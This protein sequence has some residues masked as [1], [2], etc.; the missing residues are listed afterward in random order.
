MHIEP[1][2]RRT[3]TSTDV[4]GEA[5]RVQVFFISLSSAVPVWLSWFPVSGHDL[6][7]TDGLR[8][9]SAIASRT[10]PVLALRA[11]EVRCSSASNWPSP[12]PCIAFAVHRENVCLPQIHCRRWPLV[13]CYHPCAAHG[14]SSE[15]YTRIVTTPGASI[16]P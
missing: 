6:L 16:S 1:D 12:C 10:D 14:Q 8:S 2:S 15:V 9:C 7:Q 5:E 13:I 3:R 4:A 11:R